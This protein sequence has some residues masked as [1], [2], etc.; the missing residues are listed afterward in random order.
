MFTHAA[1][2]SVG[3][4]RID[5]VGVRWNWDPTEPNK[6]KLQEQVFFYIHVGFEKDKERLC[7]LTWKCIGHGAVLMWRC[8]SVWHMWRKLD[9]I[10]SFIFCK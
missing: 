1:I 8:R 4:S 5:Q 2:H 3:V 7:S 6:K 10:C 9:F